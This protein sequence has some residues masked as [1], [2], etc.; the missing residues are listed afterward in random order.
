MNRA[1]SWPLTT[2][3]LIMEPSKEQIRSESEKREYVQPELQKREQLK[4]VTEGVA[5]VVTG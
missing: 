1:F 3:Q 2:W 5:P 4:E